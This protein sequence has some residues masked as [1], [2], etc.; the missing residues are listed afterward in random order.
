MS[1]ESPLAVDSWLSSCCIFTWLRK[2]GSSLVLFYKD[3]NPILESSTFMTQFSSK[4]PTSKYHHIGNYVSTCDFLGGKGSTNIQSVTLTLITLRY[5]SVVTCYIST[6][7]RVVTFIHLI[8]RIR[9]SIVPFICHDYLLNNV[10]KM[11]KCIRPSF[12]S[13]YKAIDKALRDP[14]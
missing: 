2:K 6:L 13:Y 8:L 10:S 11:H 4:G 7:L 1:G 9:I 12:M 5:N 3:T 14:I